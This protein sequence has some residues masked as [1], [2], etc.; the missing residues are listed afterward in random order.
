[1]KRVLVILF[2]VLA[3][4]GLAQ[5]A[6][7][8]D[9]TNTAVRAEMLKD[10]DDVQGKLTSLAKAVPEEKYGWRPAEG[11]RSVSEVYMHVAGANY[12]LL[13]F[14][15]VK[16]PEGIDMQGMEKVTEKA[17]VLDALDKSFAN[18]KKVV[19]G[20]S[21]A[22]MDKVVKIFGQDRT[23]RSVVSLIINHCHEHLGQSIAYARSNAVVPPWSAS[24]SGQ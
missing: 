19:G 16:A 6:R 4:T 9:S 20:I 5:G 14:I 23:E 21:D 18:L 3:M 17:K 24:G 2:V 22:D 15:G 7:A 12:F 8:A 1:M 10:I 13:T 11:V